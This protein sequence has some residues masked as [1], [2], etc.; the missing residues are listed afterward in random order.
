M[1]ILVPISFVL[2]VVFS[3]EPNAPTSTERNNSNNQIEELLAKMTLEE[4]IGQL[5]LYNG[6]WEFT[7][8]VPED[9]NS[10]LKA[11]NIKKGLVGGMLNVLTVEGTREAQKL[12]VENSRLGI[13]LI[14][15]YDVVHGYKTMAP[16]PLA[17]AA[18]WDAEVAQKS[19]E[20][21][22]LEAS[23]AGLHWT[24]APMVDVTRDARW[25]RMMESPGEDPYL[26]SIMSSAWVSG[27][28]GNDL[29]SNN[30]IASCAKHFAA[31]GFAEAGRDY[32]T[33]DVSMQTLYN[34]ALPPFKAAAD[35]GAATFMN[36][37][38]EIG[39]I[40]AT[41]SE[42][43][44]RDILKGEWNWDGF[45]VSDWGSIAEM[46]QHGYAE[47]LKHS[48]Y[49]ALKAGSDMDMESYAYEKELK[50]VM[51]EGSLDIALLDDAV[52]RILKVKFDLGLFD[53]P[54]KYCD[55]Q[56]EK[57]NILSE[58]NLAIARDAARKSIVLLKNE[59]NLLPLDKSGKKIAVIGSLGESKDIPLGSWRAQAVTNSAVS[60]LEGIT[61]VAGASN[62]KYAQ[63][64]KLTE[65]DRSFINELNI[66]ASDE[67]GFAEAIQAARSSDVII[68]AMGE[69]CWQTGEGRSQTDITLKGSQEALLL[70][71]LKVNKNIVVVLMNGRSLAIPKVAENAPA[72]LETWHLGSEAGNAIADVLFGDYNPSGKLPVSFPRNTGQVPIYYNLK[73]TGRPDPYPN[74][75]KMVF[76]S[77]YTDSPKTPLYSFGYGLSYTAF[78][79]SNF[80]LSSSEMDAQ[81]GITASINV[82]N[83]G[84][85][86]GHEVVQLYIRDHVGSFTRPVKELKGF[87]KVFLKK[88]EEKTIS[89]D[90]TNETLSFYRSDLT[91]GSEPGKFTIMIGS[92]SDAYAQ[93]ELQ[94]L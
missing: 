92:S 16:I 20:V 23:A 3:C 26:A 61:S 24:F 55:E 62:V 87:E 7:G 45:V 89:F 13:P 82:K 52:R 4:K 1:R 74:N 38:N 60:L 53:D 27:F 10:Q 79:Y 6:T 51:G 42:L 11:E 58:E 88:G 17:Q 73:N 77:H 32:N 67:S 72:I 64:Y 57:E 86:D 14:F 63:G 21:A 35:A 2:L 84:D 46:I 54:Y 22:A 59:N 34:V 30:T 75:D 43:L 5:N 90:I 47:D 36:A 31:Y 85:Y 41:G 80:S 18:S 68:L 70:E 49:L 37:F 93:G 15:G 9:D 48:A 66:V 69:D 83:T 71:L 12:A 91:F 65:G 50:N 78:E 33:V 25:G 44:Q 56:R 28:Q 81:E 94:L 40:P 19:A 8:P 76:W 39:G 29:S